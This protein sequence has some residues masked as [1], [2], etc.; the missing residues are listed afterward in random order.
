MSDHTNDDTKTLL[1]QVEKNAD[2]NFVR[3][4]LF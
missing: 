4:F 3:E 1:D 2:D